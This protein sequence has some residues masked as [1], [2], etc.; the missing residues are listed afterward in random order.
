MTSGPWTTAFR[1]SQYRPCVVANG[2]AGGSIGSP[3]C[4]NSPR[5]ASAAPA[6]SALQQ[7]LK[8]LDVAP[9][10]IYDD[11][12]AAQGIDIA[13]YLRTLEKFADTGDWIEPR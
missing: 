7:A 9:H 1:V 4:V 13:P 11:W 3:G 12:P 5:A 10:W 6:Q 8:D 2:S